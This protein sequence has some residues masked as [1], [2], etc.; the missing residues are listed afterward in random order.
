MRVTRLMPLALGAVLLAGC[1]GSDV[2]AVATPAVA[3]P[4]GPAPTGPAST[5]PS[6]PSE[7]APTSCPT[8]EPTAGEPWPDGV[9]TG[10]P[11]FPGQTVNTP[12]TSEGGTSTI[13]QFG[14][15]QELVPATTTVR[16]ALVPA[17]Y[18]LGEQDN[19]QDKESDTRFTGPGGSGRIKVVRLDDCLS[20]AILAFTP[21]DAAETGDPDAG[22]PDEDASPTG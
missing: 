16:D 2:P 11:V 12:T 1:G 3:T 4:T 19:E 22:E 14:I 5:A 7:P 6:S 20:R 10:F 9:P 18:V 17:G 8:G 21:G 15:P 13:V